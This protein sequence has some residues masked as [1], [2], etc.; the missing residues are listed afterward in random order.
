M[1][2]S[3]KKLTILKTENHDPDRDLFLNLPHVM[4]M[5]NHI[6]VQCR[7]CPRQG[8]IPTQ[9]HVLIRVVHVLRAG[10]GAGHDHSLLRTQHCRRQTDQDLVVQTSPSLTL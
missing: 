7:G 10:P 5:P 8:H 6:H 1:S 2:Y 9:G 4:D 3:R